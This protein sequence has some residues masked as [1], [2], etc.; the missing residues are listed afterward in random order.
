MFH[1][2]GG[3]PLRWP[4]YAALALAREV[5]RSPGRSDTG[6]PLFSCKRVSK[7]PKTR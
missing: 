7:L 1:G 3:G 5:R 6:G 4:E 2:H